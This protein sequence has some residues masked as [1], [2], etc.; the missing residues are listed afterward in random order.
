MVTSTVRSAGSPPQA[1]T[2]SRRTGLALALAAAVTG[3]VALAGADPAQAGPLVCGQEY[4]EF[5]QTTA[6]GRWRGPGSDSRSPR[7]IVLSTND[8]ERRY[9]ALSGVQRPRRTMRFT[10]VD[11][12][13]IV[14]RTV[15]TT[16]SDTGAVRP[17][18]IAW[19]APVGSRVRVYAV[20]HT[21]CGGDD[22]IREVYVGAVNTTP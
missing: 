14:I 3:A 18:V 8:L 9:L 12:N 19:D 1:V 22:V 20:I 17:F 4:A 6:D 15:E 11:E 16:P 21:R 10:F 5:Y 7:D 2:M 13:D